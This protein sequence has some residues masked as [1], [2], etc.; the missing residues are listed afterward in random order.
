MG[1]NYKKA[2]TN[3][4]SILCRSRKNGIS[5]VSDFGEEFVNDGNVFLIFKQLCNQS[6]VE[7]ISLYLDDFNNITN[8]CFLYEC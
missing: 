1:K 2:D 7:I 6:K 8:R 3:S 4:S 5:T